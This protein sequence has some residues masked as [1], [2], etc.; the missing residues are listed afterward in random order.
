MDSLQQAS[1]GEI[2]C[3]DWGYHSRQDHYSWW[4]KRM[5]YCLKLYDVVRVDHF[6]GFD[7][8]L[9]HSLWRESYR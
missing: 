8:V 4:I 2:R 7:A 9:F 6:R 3:I 1:F 5:D